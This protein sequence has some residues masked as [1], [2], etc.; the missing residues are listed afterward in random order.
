MADL[1]L[2]ELV[3]PLEPGG[4]ARANLLLWKGFGYMANGHPVT[5][6]DFVGS[7]GMAGDRG[8]CFRSWESNRWEVA[9]GLSQEFRRVGQNNSRAASAIIGNRPTTKRPSE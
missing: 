5:L 7:Q 1:Q 3:E 6:H 2:F 8:Y 9:C 4:T